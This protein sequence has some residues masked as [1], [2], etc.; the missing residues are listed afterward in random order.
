VSSTQHPFSNSKLGIKAIANL[1]S[2]LFS[3]IFSH[4]WGRKFVSFFLAGA[5]ISVTMAACTATTDNKATSPTTGG[6]PTAQTAP[7]GA[8]KKDV[9]LT[10]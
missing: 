10:L 2:N 5:L 6:S 8:P 4:K 3:N 7:A 9:E 1:F